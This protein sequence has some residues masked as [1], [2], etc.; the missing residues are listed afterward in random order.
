M[1]QNQKDPMF[2]KKLARYLAERNKWMAVV[3]DKIKYE[4]GKT[5]DSMCWAL[6][7]VFIFSIV[8]SVVY[9]KRALED[10]IQEYHPVEVVE[11]VKQENK[12]EK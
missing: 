11:E 1:N 5:V 3:D 7:F 2:E 9:T 10:H 12:E 8:A 4:L 6:L